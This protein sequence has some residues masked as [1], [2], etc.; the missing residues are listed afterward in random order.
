MSRPFNSIYSHG[1]VRAAVCVPRV[2]VAAPAYNL[3]ETL[4]LARR[5]AEAKAAVA[6]FPELGIS[7]YTSE[8]L[9]HQDALLDGVEAAIGELL[10]ASRELT[11]VVLVGAPVRAEGK[12]FNCAVVIHRGRLLGVVPKSYLPNYQEFYE[13][14]HFAAARD[15]V[16]NRVALAGQKARFSSDLIFV[17]NDVPSFRLHVEICEDL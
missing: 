14:R 13:K 5:A 16:G 4:A 9:F 15:A 1:Y 12:L 8:D 2:K 17:A 10:A 6:L 7:A 11:P 3:G